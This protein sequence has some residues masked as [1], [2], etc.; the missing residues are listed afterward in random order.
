MRSGAAGRR[1]AR[2][3]VGLGSL[4]RSSAVPRGT[5]RPRSIESGRAMSRL[6][7]LPGLELHIGGLFH[8]EQTAGVRPS[9]GAHRSGH[10][11]TAPEHGTR[12]R[13]IEGLRATGAGRVPTCSTWN[14]FPPSWPP[15]HGPCRGP[16]NTR[17]G[18]AGPQGRA[19]GRGCRLLFHV[20][21]QLGAAGGPARIGMDAGTPRRTRRPTGLG[22]MRAAMGPFTPPLFGKRH[23]ANR[24]QTPTLFA[25]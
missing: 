20:E 5:T 12:E 13:P 21:Q 23:F 19:R 22:P 10:K 6:G 15:R 25:K 14:T 9:L 11:S 4:E 16:G 1:H 8:V 3:L 7:V 18:P 2:R 17:C 24:G